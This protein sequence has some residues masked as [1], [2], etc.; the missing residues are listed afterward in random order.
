MIVFFLLNCTGWV[1]PGGARKSQQ[2]P[3]GA[4]RSQEGPGESKRKPGGARRSQGS[5]KKVCGDGNGC[6]GSNRGLR[7]HPQPCPTHSPCNVC[8]S[9]NLGRGLEQSWV[10]IL[11]WC[12]GNFWR[13]RGESSG[14]PEGSLGG[15]LGEAWA[16]VSGESRW[17][18]W[19]DLA[20]RLGAVDKVLV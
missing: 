9:R 6:D 13:R 2:E 8:N 12:L 17:R 5:Q 16:E 11:G 20:G 15:V 19:A 7:P 14:K 10:R 3:G 18:N 1:R 4:R